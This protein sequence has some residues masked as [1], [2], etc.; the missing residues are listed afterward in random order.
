MHGGRLIMTQSMNSFHLG[1]LPSAF[2][3]AP[4]GLTPLSSG[5]AQQAISTTPKAD[6]SVPALSTSMMVMQ[7]SVDRL[8]TSGQAKIAPSAVELPDIG[9]TTSGLG[10]T[11]SRIMQSIAEEGQG[12]NHEMRSSPNSSMQSSIHQ[13][14]DISF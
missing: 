2:N 4:R 10:M 14:G 11:G 9:I 12:I 13:Q 7:Q 8:F 5:R 1:G 6:E 3:L